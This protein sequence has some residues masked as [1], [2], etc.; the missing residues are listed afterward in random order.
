MPAD[1]PVT[2]PD[3]FTVAT[4]GLLLDQDPVPPLRITPLAVYVTDSLMHRGDD[5]DTE[6]TAAFGNTVSDC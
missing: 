3:P 5:P 4:A 2:T 1:T 6:A